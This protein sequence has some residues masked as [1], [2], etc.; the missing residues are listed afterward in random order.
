MSIRLID[1]IAGSN[2]TVFLFEGKQGQGKS[3]S[4]L[5]FTKEVKEKRSHLSNSTVQ[6]SPILYLKVNFLGTKKG[7]LPMQKRQEKGDLNWLMGGH[8]F[9]D[10]IGDISAS[11]SSKT[12][13]SA[14]REG[15]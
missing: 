15:I 7:L 12:S 4:Q 2:V 13:K 10:E 1:R 6:R 5:R 9:L 3:L 8:Y 11:C 14:S